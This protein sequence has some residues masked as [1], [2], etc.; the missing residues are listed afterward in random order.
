MT[1]GLTTLKHAIAKLEK[2]A[3]PFDHARLY[4]LRSGA[5]EAYRAARMEAA[6]D[7]SIDMNELM[8]AAVGYLVAMLLL[9]LERSS[10]SQILELA[11]I[12]RKCFM[13]LFDQAINDIA[14]RR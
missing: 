5:M 14:S 4:F 11:E 3:E 12:L 9:D 10:R 6:L 2:S 1:D 7:E 13:V 8:Q